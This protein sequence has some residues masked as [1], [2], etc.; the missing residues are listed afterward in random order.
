[1][2]IESIDAATLKEWLDRQNAVLIDVRDPEE[3]AA[4]NIPGAISM[5]LTTISK[6]TLPNPG[7]KRLVFHCKA[8]KRSLNACEKL[9]AEDPSLHL[10][11]LTGGISAWEEAGYVVNK[12]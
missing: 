9:I 6:N 11:S 1:M 5:P 4:E 3:H 2:A 10:F 7:N 12:P 8:G